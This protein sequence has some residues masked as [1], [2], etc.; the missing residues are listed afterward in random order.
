MILLGE[1]AVVHGMPAIAMPLVSVEAHA[2]VWP[3]QSPFL[4]VSTD[5]GREVP[6]DEAGDNDLLATAVHAAL[7]FAGVARRPSWRLE[8]TSTV[9][10]GAG[11]GSSAAVAVAAV[12]AVCRAL[13]TE[14][15]DAEV[16]GLARQAE[17]AVHGRS[18]GVDPTVCALCR[19]IVFQNG[20]P[21]PLEVGQPL[22]FV[23]ADSGRAGQTASL[24]SRVA[25]QMAASPAVYEDWMERIG[26]LTRKAVQSIRAGDARTLG[27]L[28]NQNHVVLQA[29]RVSTPMLDALVEAARTAGALGAKLT[30]AGGGGSVV[31]LT[32]EGT[33][34]A[35]AEALSRSG[36]RSVFRT[37]LAPS[38]VLD[39][40]A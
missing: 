2:V 15:T 10:I 37:T 33:Q 21:A 19:P 7:D 31:A 39:G 35:V 5:L 27:R 6:L 3:S 34:S 4:L 16:A 23:V 18:S 30:G 28:M 22:C 11:L 8:V 38:G 32:G 29:M 24:V 20:D 17:M 9:P 25:D 12:R 14:P 40:I 26:A 36:A 1:H 13:D